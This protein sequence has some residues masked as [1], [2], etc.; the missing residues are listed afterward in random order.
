MPTSLEHSV[1]VLSDLPH[2]ELMDHATW[3]ESL[4]FDCYWYA[5][6]RFYHEPYVGL[7]AIALATE[8]MR[9]GPAVGDPKTRHPALVAAAM[10]SLNELSGGRAILGFGAG[11]SG[12][13]NLGL[14]R[15]RAARAMREGIDIIDRLLDGQTVTLDGEVIQIKDAK[16]L[17]KSTRVPISVAANSP[18]TLRLAGEVGESVMIPH[19]RSVELLEHKLSF[20]REGA[21]RAGRD[22]MPRIIMRMDTSVMEDSEAAKDAAK[23]RLGRMLWQQYPKV[24]YL[25]TLG[26][27]MPA[28]LAARFEEAGP[29]V[30]TFDLSVFERFVDA[31]PDALL[32]PIALAGTSA[33][34]AEQVKMLAAAGAGEIC[35]H[36]VPAP[37][38][39]SDDVVERYASGVVAA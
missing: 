27:D 15:S 13:H 30:Y 18:M 7:A 14:S 12:F 2:R 26:I 32:E 23:R 10:N 22:E 35:I 3:V 29:F 9:I 1:L 25:E 33:E 39:S 38:Q 19:C 6:E 31:I 21:E 36:P 11:S 34:V 4:G 8:T 20:V 5:D 16:M 37:G 28:K 24:R 17:V